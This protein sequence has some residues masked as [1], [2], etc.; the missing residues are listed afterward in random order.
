M[1]AIGEKLVVLAKLWNIRSYDVKST[2]ASVE[3]RQYPSLHVHPR[4]AASICEVS[5][6]VPRLTGSADE[7]KCA[8]YGVHD[9]CA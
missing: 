6:K 5:Y 3:C 4:T 9:A 8:I 1:K 2:D 7:A